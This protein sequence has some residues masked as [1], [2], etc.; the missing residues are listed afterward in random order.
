MGRPPT[1]FTAALCFLLARR[2]AKNKSQQSTLEKCTLLYIG[3]SCSMA[4]RS[5]EFGSTVTQHL[6]LSQTFFWKKRGWEQ[7]LPFQC[8]LP[9][10]NPHSIPKTDPPHSPSP[11]SVRTPTPNP[12][13]GTIC[14]LSRF[15]FPLLTH[16]RPLLCVSCVKEEGTIRLCSVGW[17]RREKQCQTLRHATVY[18]KGEEGSLLF[19][20]EGSIDRADKY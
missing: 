3:M 19:P 15:F 5:F 12:I 17:R 16:P 1:F 20:A 18:S 2:Q 4:G 9:S 10:L 14:G 8:G 6:V 11:R 7:S 13:L